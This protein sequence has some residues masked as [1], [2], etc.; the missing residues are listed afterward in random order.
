MLLFQVVAWC[1]GT[2]GDYFST[3]VQFGHAGSSANSK[4]ETASAKNLALRQVGAHV[5]DSFDDLGKTIRL[6]LISFSADRE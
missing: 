2:C 1:I 3:E 4:L 5:P 6:I